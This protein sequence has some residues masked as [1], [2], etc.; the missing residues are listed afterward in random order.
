MFDRVLLSVH[1]SD[2][3]VRD[4]DHDGDVDF[5]IAGLNE[6]LRVIRNDHDATEKDWLVVVPRDTRA[7]IGNR[8]AIGAEIQVQ[9]GASDKR[10]TQRR[11]M[12]GGGPFQS[13]NAPEAYFGL[14]QGVDA[15]AI[16]VIFP[17]GVVVERTAVRGE[18]VFV[19]HPLDEKPR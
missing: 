6:P 10:I 19:D 4:F 15:I 1:P 13:N 14:A 2:C 11:W 18:R 8:H 17:D 12:V 9:S 3:A 7:G 16:K 5:V